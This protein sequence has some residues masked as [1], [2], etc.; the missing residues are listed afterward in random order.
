METEV[1]GVQEIAE[2]AGVTKQAVTNWRARFP[3]FPPPLAE[4]GS[5]PVFDRDRVRA[6]LLKRRKGSMAT[7]IATINMKGGVGK[8]TTSVALAQFLDAEFG[9]QVLVIDLDPQTNASLMLIGEKRWTEINEQDQTVARVFKDALDPENPKF[10]IQK[11]I[12][13][14]VGNVGDVTRVSLLPSSLDLATVQDRLAMMP[15][16]RFWAANPVDV[17]WRAVKP[18]IDEYDYVIIDCPPSLGIATWN[19]LRFANGYVIPAIPDYMSTYGIPQIVSRVAEFSRVIAESIEPLG[20]IITKRRGIALHTNQIR[21]LKSKDYA[22]V[23][24]S[25]IPESSDVAAAAEFRHH[26]TLRQKWGYQGQFAAY[27][28]LTAELLQRVEAGAAV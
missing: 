10:D 15:P 26:S 21:I 18:A 9:K 22:P 20:I 8:T 7:V 5:G 13:H 28:A 27:R 6:W 3:D 2:I 19:G 23:F 17:L 1:V 24:N 25:E 4:L 12:Q 11:S 16:G 14:H